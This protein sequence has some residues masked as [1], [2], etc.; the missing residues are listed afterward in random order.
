MNYSFSIIYQQAFKNTALSFTSMLLYSALQNIKTYCFNV[1]YATIIIITNPTSDFQQLEK[2]VFADFVVL[3]DPTNRLNL[4][5]S[6][7]PLFYVK[8]SI[9]E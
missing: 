5:S 8:H 6:Q 9:R 4:I 3:F 2:I 1:L 7:K